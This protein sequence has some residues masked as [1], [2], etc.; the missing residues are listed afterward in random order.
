MLDELLIE[1]VR[2]KVGEGRLRTARLRASDDAARISALCE[3]A[4]APA[5]SFCSFAGTSN[6]AR[7]GICG[8][9]T[10]MYR[11]ETCTPHESESLIT[12]CPACG[13]DR[14]GPP[15]S[16]DLKIRRNGKNWILGLTHYPVEARA[17]ARIF[18]VGY[19][20]LNRRLEA[21]KTWFAWPVEASGEMARE[22]AIPDAGFSRPARCRVSLAW[23]AGQ[24]V[25]ATEPC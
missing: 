15:S 20:F 24:S 22:F 5:L 14:A 9:P 7:C 4:E 8:E 1:A 18:E 3:S 10:Y 17:A 23:S 6:Q 25:C 16:P 11:H 21:D 12:L 19:S 13:T 2:G